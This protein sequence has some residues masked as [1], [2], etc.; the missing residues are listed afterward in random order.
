MDYVLIRAW[1]QYMGS[2]SYYIRDQI[3]IAKEDNAPGNAI[4]KNEDDGTWV[5]VDKLNSITRTS[6]ERMAAA[7]M[8]REN[9]DHPYGS[10]RMVR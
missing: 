8:R 7:I 1:G 5:T 9:P 6:V 10:P 2:Y 4:Y 3:A